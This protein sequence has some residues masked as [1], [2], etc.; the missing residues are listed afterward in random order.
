M[1]LG[2]GEENDF[3][4]QDS[5]VSRVHAK[6]EFRRDKFVLVDQSINGTYV[7]IYGG[8]QECV[9]R[10]EMVLRGSGIISPGRVGGNGSTECVHFLCEP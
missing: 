7:L 1:Q 2:R 8:R 6:I 5:L 3:V 9:W 4:V 10:D